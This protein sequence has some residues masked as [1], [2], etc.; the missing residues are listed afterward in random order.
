VMIDRELAADRTY[1][2]PGHYK[3]VTRP[4]LG[5][6]ITIEADKIFS[7]PGD[8]RQLSVILSAVGYPAPR[9]R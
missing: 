5:S 7:P 3:L 9:I 1:P 6:A 2:A 4:A 8:Q